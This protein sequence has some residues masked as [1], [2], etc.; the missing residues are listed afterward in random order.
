MSAVDRVSA[1]Y[2]LRLTDGTVLEADAVV[3]ALP[4]FAAGDLLAELS[5]PAADAL[6]LVRYSSVATVTLSYPRAAV[7]RDLDGTGFLGSHR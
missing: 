4:A 2:R 6:S 7:G 1:G 3:L 5:P